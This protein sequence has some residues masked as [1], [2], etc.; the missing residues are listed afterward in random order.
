[1]SDAAEKA[2]AASFAK[3]LA[4]EAFFQINGNGNLIRRDLSAATVAYFAA[5]DGLSGAAFTEQTRKWIALTAENP[6]K[7]AI[8]SYF[9]C[10]SDAE[11]VEAEGQAEWL[12][13]LQQE[14][15]AA[16]LITDFVLIRLRQ[17]QYQLSHGR[18][19]GDRKIRKIL[20]RLLAESGSDPVPEEG[21][22]RIS[23][24]RKPN[25]TVKHY[26]LNPV[27]FLIFAVLRK[28]NFEIGI[29]SK[30]SK[31]A[32]QTN[33]SNDYFCLTLT[34][35][36]DFHLKKVAKIAEFFRFQRKILQFFC[37]FWIFRNSNKSQFV[38]IANW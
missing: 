24:S 20:E 9:F 23:V 36:D 35:F 32:S 31:I 21:T 3:A 8:F 30:I 15:D 12:P 26:G 4:D 6:R 10:I 16:G 33:L 28:K 18:K 37:E 1:M 13:A 17:K 14:A 11:E 7:Q 29:Q 38:G 27:F 2:F 25:P 5:L 22:F 34:I 19:I